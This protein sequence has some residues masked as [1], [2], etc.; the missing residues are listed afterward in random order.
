MTDSDDDFALLERWRAGETPAGQMLVRRHTP[1]LHRFFASK[2]PEAVEDL[3]Q[4]TFLAAVESRD[5]FREDAAFRTYVL[6]IAR[7]SLFK[8]YR[9]RIRG[10]RALALEAVCAEQVSGSP[11][12]AAAARQELRLLLAALRQIPIDQQIAIELY[13][14]EDLPIAEIATVLEVAPGTIKSRLARAREQLRDAILTGP[15]PEPLRKTTIDEL[16]RWARELR[17]TPPP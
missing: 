12:L 3:V 17:P 8:H 16:D 15:A 7:K 10:Q 11:S 14:W 2:A 13:Y 5:R 4:A 1:T 9:K 6:A